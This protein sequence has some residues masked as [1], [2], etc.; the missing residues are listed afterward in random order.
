MYL[1]VQLADSSTSRLWERP[2]FYVLLLES[3]LLFTCGSDGVFTF[4]YTG[5]LTEHVHSS[6]VTPWLSEQWFSPT[7]ALDYCISNNLK[8]HFLPGSPFHF[9]S[10]VCTTH[11]TSSIIQDNSYI[12]FVC[13]WTLRWTFNKS[14]PLQQQHQLHWHLPTVCCM[15]HWW[16]FVAT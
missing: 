9:M 16:L 6:T 14:A 5:G 8:E 1:V 7:L 11:P 3:A 2:D 15:Y 13:L 4:I 12:Q 10:C